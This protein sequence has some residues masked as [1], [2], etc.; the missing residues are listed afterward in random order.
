MPYWNKDLRP[1]ISQ[2]PTFAMEAVLLITLTA[3][4][5]ASIPGH[6]IAQTKGSISP[7]CQR[8]NQE[9]GDVNDNL[10]VFSIKLFIFAIC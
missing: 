8:K 4:W 9:A 6:E 3:G 10:S 1:I 5:S 2:D 7:L